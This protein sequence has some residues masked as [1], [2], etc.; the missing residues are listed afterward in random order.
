MHI[1]PSDVEVLNSILGLLAAGLGLGSLFGFGGGG[2]SALGAASNLYGAQMASDATQRA[3]ELNAELTREQ[4]E[5][6]KEFAQKG[7]RWRTLDAKKAGIHPLAALGANT[8][9]YS[10]SM[11]GAQTDD[12]MARA[13]ADI[14]SKL[15][16][17]ISNKMLRSVQSESAE[18]ALQMARSQLRGSELENDLLQ[19]QIDSYSNQPRSNDAISPASKNPSDAVI[20]TPNVRLASESTEAAHMTAA[21]QPK[22]VPHYSATGVQMFYGEETGDQISESLLD[23]AK[24]YYERFAEPY[25]T[26]DALQ[27]T[28]KMIKQRWP[29]ATGMIWKDFEWQPYFGKDRNPDRFRVMWWEKDNDILRR[30]GSYVSKGVR[31]VRDKWQRDKIAYKKW[32]DSQSQ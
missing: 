4:M 16:Q 30:L 22:Y 31:A 21:V 29:K 10:P 32:L 15:G 9:S 8:I 20:V 14:G 18:I 17:N 11:I 3:N 23:K 1:L 13:V 28:K 5:L 19:K 6:Q 24:G 26:S 2:S 12:H 27:P 25:L 7:V